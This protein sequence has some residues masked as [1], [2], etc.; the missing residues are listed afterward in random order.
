MRVVYAYWCT[1][2]GAAATALRFLVLGEDTAMRLL[3]SHSF[4]SLG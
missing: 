1:V 2:F 3:V 4:F